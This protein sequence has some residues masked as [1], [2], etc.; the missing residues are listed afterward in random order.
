MAD[1]RQR[2]TCVGSLVDSLETR[3]P[4]DTNK[5]KVG[6]ARRYRFRTTRRHP[7]HWPLTEKAGVQHQP[8]SQ[9]LGKEGA[10]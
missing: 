3:D 4:S 7:Y 5:S 9:G 8:V 1:S 6:L 10:Q 2:L